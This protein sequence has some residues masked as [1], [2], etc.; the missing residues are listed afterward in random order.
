MYS[1]DEDSFEAFL[2]A[3]FAPP[4]TVS[5]APPPAHD[6]PEHG[7]DAVADLGADRWLPF[8]KRWTFESLL[9]D[10]SR[11]DGAAV[12]AVAGSFLDVLTRCRC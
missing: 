5:P 2:R 3:K 8:V 4:P 10:L 12:S 11:E 7:L 6:E 9:V 1:E